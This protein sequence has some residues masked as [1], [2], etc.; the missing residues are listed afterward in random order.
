M[1][2]SWD[3]LFK[4]HASRS[5]LAALVTTGIALVSSDVLAQVHFAD[6]AHVCAWTGPN[7]APSETGCTPACADDMSLI[8]D[9]YNVD[10]PPAP[11]LMRPLEA[12]GLVPASVPDPAYAGYTGPVALA[13]GGSGQYSPID[14]ATAVFPHGKKVPGMKQILPFMRSSY[15]GRLQI[16]P[17]SLTGSLLRPA[18][19][20]FRPE[21]VGYDFT[22]GA[23]PA[24][25]SSA[26]SAMGPY[27]SLAPVMYQNPLDT[28]MSFATHPERHGEGAF[29]HYTI[30]D[31]SSPARELPEG[32]ARNPVACLAP[33]RIADEALGDPTL[34][35]EG[36]CYQISVLLQGTPSWTLSAWE[37]RSTDLTVF[38]PHAKRDGQGLPAGAQR[39][40]IYPRLELSPAPPDVPVLPAL[41]HFE[42]YPMPEAIEAAYRSAHQI[43]NAALSPAENADITA[44]YADALGV[45]YQP[46]DS[47][48]RPRWCEFLDVQ[49]HNNTFTLHHAQ[50]APEQWTSSEAQQKYHLF[51]PSLTG[52]GRL[53]VLN[54][55]GFGLAYSYNALGACRAD[56][57]T[58]L[59]HV[60][61]I[62]WDEDINTRYPI[63]M[64]QVGPGANT[65]GTSRYFRDTKGRDIH[66]REPIPGAY[67]WIDREGRNLFFAAVNEARDGWKAA[68]QSDCLP[69]SLY[70]GWCNAQAN[71]LNPDIDPGKGVAALGAW[72]QGKMV[73]LDNGLNMSDFGN[74]LNYGLQRDAFQM[75]LYQDDP[76]TPADEADLTIRPRGTRALL[77]PENQYHTY[78]ALSPVLPFDVV[79]SFASDTQRN[80]EVA[81]DDYLQNDALVVAHMNAPLEIDDK[82]RWFP[83]D[84]FVPTN[85]AAYV[86]YVSA[87][88]DRAGYYFARTPRLQNAATSDE[89]FAPDAVH[90][91]SALLL[92]GGARVEPMGE[93]GVLGKGVYLD[94]NNDFVDVG[95]IYTT[96]DDWY[97]GLW[98]D[99]REREAGVRRVVLAFADQSFIE[100]SRKEIVAFDAMVPGQGARRSID[101]SRVGL[102]EGEYY[103]LGVSIT[104]EGDERV[105]RF[106]INGTRLGNGELRYPLASPDPYDRGF[107]LRLASLGDWGWY[108]VGGLPQPNH[109]EAPSGLLP[110][111]GWVD[112]LRTYRVSPAV[113]AGSYLDEVACNLALGTL[114]KVT[115]TSHDASSPLLGPLYATAWEHG[116]VNVDPRFLIIDSPGDDQPAVLEKAAD[117]PIFCEGGRSCDRGASAY[118]CEQMR[119]HSYD[120]SLDFPAQGHE[121]ACIDRVHRN[122]HADPQI[123]ARCMRRPVLGLTG[124]ALAHSV[125]RPDFAPVAFCGTCHSSS[126]H[127]DSLRDVALFPGAVPRELD[128]R[129]QPMDV[130]ALLSGRVPTVDGVT[131]QGPLSFPSPLN[132]GL[133]LDQFF[134]HAP[135]IAP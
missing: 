90:P 69:G 37:M 121:R 135:K 23:D 78:D 124:L 28:S 130:P 29:V 40:W 93:G 54:V 110:W 115:A 5:P 36:D 89:F 3:R 2:D 19:A 59:K 113:A 26:I 92:R 102:R 55:G 32:R 31:D 120:Q 105:L 133:P 109:P 104:T 53:L 30:C 14:L 45:C 60:S 38:V 17:G 68:S 100:M 88:A 50:G 64:N 46:V 22:L 81:F 71:F 13:V 66:W 42:G 84:G 10:A 15:D 21:A 63:G 8:D 85:P 103:H 9:C 91:P 27:M 34:L 72:T 99:S 80:A 49:H 117:G 56:G 132:A 125:P 122:P 61:E 106:T 44:L 70:W 57:F 33:S 134:D 95:G 128:S 79:W 20:V 41:E 1:I 129:R 52:D 51:E 77:S 86:R 101:I 111:K 65:C 24:D 43:G 83:E 108:V 7:Q 6:A 127:L 47:V 96:D 94:G 123:A 98:L 39:P 62:P 67:G 16:F 25:P 35:V 58:D 48:T 12:A 75:A 74:H 73:V 126:A 118:V 116:L 82:Q 114:V 11:S 18:F 87:P 97:H 112:E 4:F 107:A 131:P 76:A 119:L